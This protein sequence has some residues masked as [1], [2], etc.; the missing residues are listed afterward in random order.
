VTARGLVAVVVL[1]A[2]GAGIAAFAQREL[3][4]SPRERLAEAA[5]RIAPGAS[6]FAVERAGRHIGFASSTVDTIPGGLQ[7]TD[8]QVADAEGHG[9][10]ERATTQSVARLSRGLVLRDFSVS[11]GSASGAVKATGRVAG[12][13]VLEYAVERP[14]QTTD[15][16]RVSLS[17]PLLLPSQVAMAIALGERLEEGQLHRYETFDPVTLRHQSLRVAVR[18][19]S[20]FVVVDS[21]AFDPN[22]RR[23]LGAHADTVRAFHLRAEAPAALDLWVDE[24]GRPV[25]IAASREV[26]LRRTAYEVAFENWRTASPLRRAASSERAGHWSR[27]IIAAGLVS[28]ASERDSLRVLVR[29][30]A[31]SGLAAHGGSQQVEGD[32][33][34]IARDAADVLRPSFPLPTSAATRARFSRDLRAEPLLEVE[35]PALVTLARRLRARDA[36]ADV[37]VR[38]LM[39]WVHDSVVGEP[40]AALP[41]ALATFR[42]RRGDVG[43][44]A[45]LLV[46]L[47]RAAGIPART[48]SGVLLLDGSFHY[49]AWAEVMLQRWVGVD[50]VLGQF[51]TDA[52]HLRLLADGLGAHAELARLLDGS[53]LTVLTPAAGSSR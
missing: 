47:A 17:G 36:Q 35:H 46:A 15:T 7:V 38:R 37:V 2:W 25:R 43:E 21:A 3:N 28:R 48:V 29:G 34:G 22:S 9:G 5:M 18:A 26:T 4:R 20:V 53:E 1:A 33:V 13:S 44:Q 24:L 23:W 19:E 12:D 10:L 14:G 45:Q 50:P 49:H 39:Q 42:S 30:L 52:S 16:T 40:A 27:S 6:Y 32:T 51:P 31:L 41:S 11:H 8:Y